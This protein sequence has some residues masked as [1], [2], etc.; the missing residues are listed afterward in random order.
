MKK[1]RNYKFKLPLL[2]IILILTVVFGL[3]VYTQGAR[4][5]A[6]VQ[7]VSQDL[8][9]SL[10]Y[11][12]GWY[13]D[14]RYHSILLTDY[15]TNLNRDDKPSNNQ[16]EIYIREFSNCFPSLE[17]DLKYPACGQRKDG[18]PNNIISK[19]TKQVPGGTFYKYITKSPENKEFVYYFLERG[20]R[21]LQISKEPDP[22]KFEKE[23]K[24]IINSIRFN[25]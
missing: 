25:Y 21:L 17:E 6:V 20:D 22:S 7:R 16:I 5:S 9:I 8:K 4:Q 14:D 19:E 13:I 12:R 3:I 1:L 24:E 2:F 10:S 15:K 11:P 23:F 18:Q